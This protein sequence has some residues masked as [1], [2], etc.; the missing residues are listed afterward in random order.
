LLDWW[1]HWRDA[2]H[3]AAPVTLG[4]KQQRFISRL[5]NACS[6]KLKELNEDPSSGAP[7]CRAVEKEHEHGRK[8]EG[9]SW[10]APGEEP[11]VRTI[12]LH[13]NVTAYGASQCWEREKGAKV[14]VG[15]WI[16]WTDRSCSDNS[17]VGAAAVCNHR[18]E[19]K[20]CRSY[21]GTGRMEVFDVELLA[22]GL[23]VGEMIKNK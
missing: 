17:R 3:T 4:Y 14:G 23:R 16:W 8:T 15:V 10:P 11:V 19:W 22:I 20:T 12:I 5:A 13:D 6:S 2:G 9:I 1:N 18:N 21:L 7:I